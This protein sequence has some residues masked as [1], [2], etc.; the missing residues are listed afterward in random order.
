MWIRENRCET[1]RNPKTIRFQID[2]GVGDGVSTHAHLQ[3]L[4]PK[5]FVNPI[6]AFRSFWRRRAPSATSR[7]VDSLLNIFGAEAESVGFR[8]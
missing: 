4:I 2:T 8:G 6:L 3:A 1:I 7:G 5:P